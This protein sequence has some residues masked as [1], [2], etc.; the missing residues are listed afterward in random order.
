MFDT[1]KANWQ[2]LRRAPAGERFQQYYQRRQQ[3]RSS[4]ALRILLLGVGALVVVIGVILMPAPGPGML[5]VAVGLATM[6]GES[7]S[8][9]RA[10][11][12]GERRLRALWQ[13]WRKR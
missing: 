12:A 3:H 5:I 1:L 10:L 11:D 4:G 8:V 13:R 9:A 7:R 6:A 2:H